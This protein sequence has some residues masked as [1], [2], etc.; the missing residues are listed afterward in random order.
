MAK[1]PEDVKV[2]LR[3]GL[4]FEGSLSEI[5]KAMAELEALPAEGVKIGTWPTPERPAGG[6][7]IK[8]VPLPLIDTVPLPEGPPGIWPVAKLL[9]PK[10]SQ[11][12]S[13]GMPRLKMIKGIE[14]GIRNPHLHIGDEVVLL[15]R[16]RFK[17]VVRRAAQEL[18]DALAESVEY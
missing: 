14:G 11:E 3:V 15:D 6:M 12:L 1:G 2:F 16:E 13:K 8:T 5:Q 17:D 9:G 10:L 4:Q 7:T 18:T